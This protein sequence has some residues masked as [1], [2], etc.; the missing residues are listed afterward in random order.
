MA[1]SSFGTD[2]GTGYGTWTPSSSGT[3]SY[4]IT[5]ELDSSST[6]EGESVTALEFTWEVQAG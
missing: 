5:V 4:R 2:Y 6:A 1:L 3:T